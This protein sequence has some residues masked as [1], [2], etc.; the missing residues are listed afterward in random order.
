MNLP[1]ISSAKD[2]ANG[3]TDD[4]SSAPAA[5]VIAPRY[6]DILPEN[7]AS[8]LFNVSFTLVD[9]SIEMGKFGGIAALTNGMKIELAETD[10]TILE[11]FGD[12]HLFKTS[13]DFSILSGSYELL[14]PSAG[15]DLLVVHWNLADYFGDGLHGI[16]LKGHKI[17]ITL[18]DDLSGLTVFEAHGHGIH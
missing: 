9:A 15:D 4:M 1:W 16:A 8:M 6:F 3:D 18:Q 13:A 17:R 11:S 7:D 5:T 10:N 2:A 14:A 12:G